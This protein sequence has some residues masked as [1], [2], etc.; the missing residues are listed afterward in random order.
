MFFDRLTFSTF[1][2]FG[3]ILNVSTLSKLS[4]EANSQTKTDKSQGFFT[5]EPKVKIS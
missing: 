1:Q 5:Y 3:S 4:L 2:C